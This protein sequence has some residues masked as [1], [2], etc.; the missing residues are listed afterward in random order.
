MSYTGPPPVETTAQARDILVNFRIP[1]H[2]IISRWWGGTVVVKIVI[3]LSALYKVRQKRV[4][5]ILLACFL[6]AT[7]LTV[8]QLFAQSNVLALLFPWRI[9]ATLLPLSTSMVAAYL[10]TAFIDRLVPES[11]KFDTI[12]MALSISGIAFLVLVGVF[13]IKVDLDR[14]VTAI[15]R[16]MMSFVEQNKTSKD[17]FL[18]PTKMQDFRLTTGAPIYID[19]KSIPYMDEDVL[20]WYRRLKLARR[21]YRSGKENCEMMEQFA[22]EEG[23]THVVLESD[24]PTQN[25]A[26]LQETYRDE[27]YAVYAIANP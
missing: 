26:P 20:E 12:I 22:A 24:D 17:V 23:V 11:S 25:C 18:I 19:F 16:A 1:H 15:D 2:A 13:R 4:F 8:V 5:P 6:V 9:S 27:N 3:I 10:V 14:K 7:I 21:L